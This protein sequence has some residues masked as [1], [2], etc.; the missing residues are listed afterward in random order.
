MI[1]QRELKPVGVEAFNIQ[2][3]IAILAVVGIT[4]H[5]LLRFLIPS[6]SPYSIYPLYITLSLVGFLPPVAG[7]ITQEVIDVFAILN[8]LRTIWKP[9][10]L[11]DIPPNTIEIE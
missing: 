4:M 7:A 9:K 6:L 11:S 3:H 2:P 5:L 10:L 8:S 1:D